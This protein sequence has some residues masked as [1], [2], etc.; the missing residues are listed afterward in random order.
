M[1]LK[2]QDDVRVSQTSPTQEGQERTLATRKALLLTAERLY[3]RLGIDGVSLREINREAQQK[4]R[5]AVHY[6][7]G[8]REAVIEGIFEMRAAQ[9]NR[10]RRE[11]LAE[12]RARNATVT[13]RELIDGII[14][15]QVE[16]WKQEIDPY[17]YNRFLAQAVLSGHDELRVMW[18][19]YFGRVLQDY[20]KNIRELLPV[21]P[22]AV[23][24]QRL[25]VSTDFAIYGL[26]N[27]ERVVESSR[28]TNA[29]FSFD[30]AIE[31]LIDM[32]TASIS[33]LP[34]KST[35]SVVVRE[36]PLN[37]T[38]GKANKR[39]PRAS[40]TP[41]LVARQAPTRSRS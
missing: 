25:A 17:H 29:P 21:L 20:W 9:I 3:A 19:K 35:L 34:S 18:R 23:L 11:L 10:R 22:D 12:L 38:A 14:R 31:N 6:H 16:V 40:P 39:S 5:S 32:L 30:R 15:P 24:R 41:R 2:T 26:A 27:L 1:A 8:S 36:G 37:R 4:N 7:F 33:A 28:A 13:V